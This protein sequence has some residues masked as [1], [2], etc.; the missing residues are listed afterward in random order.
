MVR[1]DSPENLGTAERAESYGD[2]TIEALLGRTSAQLDQARADVA[3]T[4][5]LQARLLEEI[6]RLERRLE[7]AEAERLELLEK[8]TH[9]DRLLGQIFAS[10]SWRWANALRRLLG[11]P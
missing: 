9:R 5:R 3:L 11:R 10:R 8:V 6:E 1:G 4:A 7:D 2:A